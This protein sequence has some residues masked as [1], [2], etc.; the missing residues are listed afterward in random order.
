MNDFLQF[1]LQLF[2]RAMGLAVLA[3]L[4]SGVCLAA[5][6]VIFRKV[7]KGEKKFPWL[8]AF[9]ALA[10]VGWL[11]VVV[12]V[13]LLRFSGMGYAATNFHLFRAWREAWNGWSAKGWLNVLL[14]VAMF[15]PLGVLLP[16]LSRR[17]EKWYWTL[18]LSF[19]ATLAIEVNQYLTCVGLFDVDDLFCNT[20]GAM[21]GYCLVMVILKLCRKQGRRSLPYLACPALFALVL[22]CIFG[23]YQM[24]ELGNLEEAPVFTANT[25]GIDWVLDCTLDNTVTQAPVYRTQTL[26]KSSGDAFAAQFAEKAGITFPDVSYYDHLAIYMNHS[27]GDFLDLYYQDGSYDYKVGC[28]SDPALF[29]LPHTEV[30]AEVLR[31]TLAK[32]DIHIPPTAEHN[33]DGY[34][35]TFTVHMDHSEEDMRDGY[36]RV[37]VLDGDLVSRIENHLVTFVHYDQFPILTQQQAY[38]QLS[39]GKFSSGEQFE[40]YDPKSVTVLDCRMEYRIDTKGF[41]QP[42]YV[43]DVASDTHEPGQLGQLLVPA[44]K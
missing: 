3:V 20:L 38:E 6:Y 29:D 24:K 8:K 13:T 25:R 43:F 15:A 9:S 7:T 21:L 26:D 27:T 14:N 17:F 30:D 4:V 41:Y 23:G 10:L 37:T 2:H 22:V 28:G 42:V 11:V 16:L 34:D 5:A 39:A 35:N 40:Y 44:L 18:A 36:V 12:Y 31:D 19:G 1:I 32:Y 33:F